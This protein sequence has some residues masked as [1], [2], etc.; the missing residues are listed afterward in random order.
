MEGNNLLNNLYFNP[1]DNASN[2]QKKEKGFHLKEDKN[3]QDNNNNNE[4]LILKSQ[5]ELNSPVMGSVIIQNWETKKNIPSDIGELIHYP[6]FIDRKKYK[7]EKDDSIKALP[8]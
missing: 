3:N 1:L 6:I 2:N 7:Q 4:N 5:K 8:A